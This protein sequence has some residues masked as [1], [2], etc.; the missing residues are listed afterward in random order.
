MRSMVEGP[1]RRK[2]PL[3]RPSGGPPPLKKQGRS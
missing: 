1:F 2:K 3:H